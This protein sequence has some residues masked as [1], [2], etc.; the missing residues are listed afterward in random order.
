MTQLPLPLGPFPACVGCDD[1]R[2]VPPPFEGMEPEPCP[3]CQER[4][5]FSWQADPYGLRR[6][7]PEPTRAERMAS[8][9]HIPARVG[10]LGLVALL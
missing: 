7:S 8:I 9:F 4:R 5:W 3:L 2:L 1:A 6:D 10:Q